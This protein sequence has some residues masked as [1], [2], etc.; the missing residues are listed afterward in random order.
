M[1]DFKGALMIRVRQIKSIWPVLLVMLFALSCSG[2]EGEDLLTQA[3]ELILKG[4]STSDKKYFLQAWKTLD[5]LLAREPENVDALIMLGRL[6]HPNFGPY[7]DIEG[8]GNIAEKALH[9]AVRIDL[10]HVEAAGLLGMLLSGSE[11]R[12]EL[13]RAEKL[14]LRVIKENPADSQA[15]S[16]LAKIYWRLDRKEDAKVTAFRAVKL[17]QTLNSVHHVQQARKVL[18]DIYFEKGDKGQAEYVFTDAILRQKRYHYHQ[19]DGTYWGCAYQ[20]LGEL[21]V[22]LIKTA[23]TNIDAAELNGATPDKLFDAAIRR[24]EAG[25]ID[26]ATAIVEKARAGSSD[27]RLDVFYGFLL[28]FERK[29][30]QAKGLFDGASNKSE[31]ST[32]AGA[33]LGHIGIIEKDYE[34]AQSNLALAYGAMEDSSLVKPYNRWIYKMICLGLGWQYANRNMH[35]DAL[36]YFGKVLANNGRDQMALLGKGNSLIG[37]GRLNEAEKVMNLVLDL[38]PGNQ[39]A[40][41]EL[42]MIRL[43]KGKAS[44]AEKG[45]EQ[46]LESGQNSYTCPYEGLGIIYLKQGRVDQAQKSFEKAIK[47]NPDIEY[48]KFNGLAK[49]F[50]QRGNYEKARELLKKSIQNFPHDPEA[51][52]LLAQMEKLQK[53]EK[54]VSAKDLTREK[55]LYTMV[56]LGLAVPVNFLMIQNESQEFDYSSREIDQANGIIY[57]D[58][59]PVGLDLVAVDPDMAAKIINEYP[60][61]AASI[62]IDMN[63]LS[64]KAVIDAFRN[65]GN[66]R[67]S[68]TVAFSGNDNQGL[69]MLEALSA[70]ELYLD[71]R[72]AGKVS[73]APLSKLGNVVELKLEG[74]GI[75]DETLSEIKGCSNLRVLEL[76]DGNVTDR[77]LARLADKKTLR[78][79]NLW[80]NPVSGTG[81]SHLSSLNNLRD[82]ELGYSLINDA[83]L[84]HLTGL[85]NLKRLGLGSTKITGEGMGYVAM[86]PALR[87]LEVWYTDLNDFGLMALSQMNNLEELDIWYTRITDAGLPHLAGCRSLT[88]LGLGGTNISDVGAEHL[89]TLVNLTELDLWGTKIGDRG[90]EHIASCKNL[91]E[92][93][94]GDTPVTDQGIKA[95]AKLPSL[96]GLRL[97]STD[98]TDF[99]LEHLKGNSK[100]EE[101]ELFNTKVGDG[102]LSHLAVLKELRFIDLTSTN[103]GNEGLTALSE[104]KNL[105]ELEIGLTRVTDEGLHRI[106]GMESLRELGLSGNRITDKGLEPLKNLKDLKELGL[107]GTKITDNGLKNLGG[108]T[109]L[110]LLELGATDIT[111]QCFIH[112]G[113]LINL[114]YLGIGS[115][116]VKGE[117]FE[118]IVALTK[119]RELDVWGNSINDSTIH[120]ILNLWRLSE[121]EL[122]ETEITDNGLAQLS[123]MT[124]LKTIEIGY[125]DITKAGISRLKE[126][127]PGLEVR[128]ISDF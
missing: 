68:V 98:I 52:I 43:G 74:K 77:G 123:K 62:R 48:K 7:G 69:N 1:R 18:G 86:L 6:Y 53:L 34:A 20:G 83:A 41:A 23:D 45:F 8:A 120:G 73:L 25:D 16:F 61:A 33:G 35:K 12:E 110:Q 59:E 42:A 58:G 107:G 44:D 121:L 70:E 10:D 88:R 91:E 122:G 112:L 3:D 78:K 31:S 124:N 30:A 117:K 4:Y 67:F 28:L 56:P 46:A 51:G 2:G 13:I 81:L 114:R 47:I 111:D 57:M 79:L 84:I 76:P 125:T 89:A 27:G 64:Q 113:S 40:L 116:R 49:I 92:L 106:A 50:I 60:K 29:Y 127:L 19:T 72:Q 96:R 85:I 119:L 97:W 80:G 26:E 101:I 65:S 93:N 128:E 126:E 66:K 105:R 36:V 24:F 108:L 102:G 32:G 54:A 82:L 17:A 11:D 103:I 15:H 100:L 95:L 71:L 14:L 104:L 22:K 21:Y 109:D 87:V 38:Y 118:D 39:Y 94:L 63:L 115:T 5:R 75:T 9:S 99:G 90:L 37:L 55:D